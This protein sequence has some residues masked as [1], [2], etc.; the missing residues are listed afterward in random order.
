MVGDYRMG[1]TT[2]A[3]NILRGV[4][5]KLSFDP[6]YA[7]PY[8][9]RTVED[10][11]RV[12]ATYGTCTFQPGRNRDP[13]ELGKKLDAFCNLALD[14]SNA[15]VFIDELNLVKV[16]PQSYYDLEAL[17]HKRNLGIMT[18]VHRIQGE[19]PA[20]FQIHDHF[21]AF[22]CSVVYDLYTLKGIIGD[23]GAAYVQ[24]APKYFFWYKGP[25]WSGPCKSPGP[26]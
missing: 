25:S 4:P 23:T 19:I 2:L 18:A 26:V 10:A 12:F 5:R 6:T 22:H 9:Q 8:G 13:R 7:F 15:L 11:A 3:R 14:Q 21:F 16:I 1:K 24:G 20:I 17:G